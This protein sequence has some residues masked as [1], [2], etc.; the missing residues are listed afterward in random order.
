MR[1][2]RT[3]GWIE[4]GGDYSLTVIH[5]RTPPAIAGK[6]SRA[7]WRTA[8]APWSEIDAIS[9]NIEPV[10]SVEP[11]ISKETQQKCPGENLV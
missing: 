6:W 10:M 2:G 7:L 11:K 1:I 9:T 3:P 4:R 5:V 8:T